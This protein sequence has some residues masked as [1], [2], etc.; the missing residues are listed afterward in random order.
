M[1][2]LPTI[3]RV[4]EKKSEVPEEPQGE[5]IT[6][7]Y[8]YRENSVVLID[9]EQSIPAASMRGEITVGLMQPLVGLSPLRGILLQI[10]DLN[11]SAL[12][13]AD[14]AFQK[15]V[16]SKVDG[17]WFRLG[18]PILAPE[19]ETII[20]QLIPAA[21]HFWESRTANGLC[22]I[23]L[24]FPE[25]V[26][27][28]IYKDGWIFIV[29]T[30][31][32]N[33]YKVRSHIAR[34]TRASRQDLLARIPELAS[35]SDR[36]ISIVGL[37][38]VGAPSALQFAKAGVGKIRMLDDDFVDPAAS[39][40]WPLGFSSAGKSKVTALE[41]FI[42]KN[43]PYTEVKPYFYRI[44]AALVTDE[45]HVIEDFV[46]DTDLIYDASAEIGVNHFLS[47]LARDLRLPYIAVS[48]TPGGWG[49]RIIRHRPGITEGCWMCARHAF[50]SE[51]ILLP[52]MSDEFVQ[53]E[54]CASPTFTGASFDVE[55]VALMG[56]RVVADTLTT[57][58]RRYPSLN[59]DIA[60]LTIRNESGAIVGPVW[61]TYPLQRSPNC[62]NCST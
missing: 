62:E 13:T 56:M 2:Q 1:A 53:P 34:A 57:G 46:R 51:N 11:S 17:R 32:K 44:G 14:K 27:Q 41:E 35:L 45:R 3:L 38:C 29:G 9:S 16:I 39:V 21:R 52:P 24:V 4:T 48:S 23:G 15:M 18:A 28:N 54:G 58:D 47:D 49:G 12:V 36:T 8:R 61:Q 37:G 6:D 59:W 20:G 43:Y 31:Q 22:V 60:V 5:P 10:R 25:E 7:F 40:R 26:N 33:D 19:P 50:D 42:K 55:E 30:K